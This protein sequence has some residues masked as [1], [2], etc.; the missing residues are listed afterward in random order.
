M[1]QLNPRVAKSH[2][3]QFQL[4]AMLPAKLIKSAKT[5]LLGAGLLAA[6]M[7]VPAQAGAITGQVFYLENNTGTYL[8]STTALPTGDGFKGLSITTPLTWTTAAGL[9]DTVG[10]GYWNVTLFSNSPGAS[11]IVQ[12]DI[13][14][15][16][17]SIGHIST[18]VNLSGAGNH[19][20]N[21]AIPVTSAITF[22]NQTLGIKV[23]QVSGAA[24]KVAADGDF[25]SP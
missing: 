4:W 22:S 25:P 19:T 20:T 24:A 14:Q 7:I 23:T 10:V 16:G 21:F 11:S 2:L 1:N 9:S 12:V 17:T 15:N 6:G 8:L 18:D 13:L 5:L 3:K